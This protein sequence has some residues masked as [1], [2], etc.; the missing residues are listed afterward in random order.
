[1]L[2]SDK[3]DINRPNTNHNAGKSFV[4]FNKIPYIVFSQLPSAI[5]QN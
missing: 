1:M 4:S 5:W 3:A 2:P